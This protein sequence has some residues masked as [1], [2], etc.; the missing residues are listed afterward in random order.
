MRTWF[1]SWRRNTGKTLKIMQIIALLAAIMLI[2]SFIGGYFLNWTWT[3]FGPYIPPTSNFQREKTLYD[4]LK[5]A[6]VPVAI[7]LGVWWLTR[8]QQQRDQRRADQ[9][10]TIEREATEKRAQ[11]ERDIALDK[12]R[13]D[14]LQTYLD[15]MSELLLEKKLCTSAPTD[16]ARKIARIR[17]ITILFQLDARRIGY[18]FAFLREAGLI[19]T[20]SE[21]IVSLKQANLNKINFSRASIEQADLREAYLNTSDL[22]FANLGFSNLSGAYLNT[23]SLSGANLNGVDLSKAHLYRANL[24]KTRI[25]IHDPY[26]AILEGANFSKAHLW[27][28]DLSEADL[29]EANFKGS[30]LSGANLSRANLSG[31]DFSE[32]NLS[33]T[34]MQGVKGLTTEELKKYQS[35]GAII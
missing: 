5:L 24:S 4:W 20:T 22:S 2:L 35:L 7:S 18:V 1:G 6:I 34:L 26:T 23:A 31:A 19:S 17:T 11:A 14:L 30:D 13:E 8:L 28:A 10:A 33:G 16:E 21:S 15:R 3:G 29:W 32:A 12:Q 25:G 9:Q 27:E